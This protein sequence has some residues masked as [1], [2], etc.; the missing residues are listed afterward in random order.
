[1]SYLLG[2]DVGTSSLK[3]ALFDAECAQLVATAAEEYPVHQPV[4]NAAEQTP[5]TWW[6]AAL[7]AT[8]CVLQGVDRKRVRGIG[9]TGQM[10]GTVLLDAAAQPLRPAIIWADGRSSAQVE[11]LLTLFRES[12]W[13]D[14]AGTLPAT[15]FMAATL[16]WLAEHESETLERAKS[17][18]LPKDYIRLKLTGELGS[19]PSDAAS[20]AL[21]D[22][23]SANWSERLIEGLGLPRTLFPPIHGSAEVTGTLRAEVAE[24]LGLSAGLPVVAG[25][26]DQ[27]AQALANNVLARG[28]ASV[29]IGSG[30]QVFVPHMPNNHGELA[31]DQRVHV[32]NHAAPRHWY[33][34]GAILS[35]GLSLRWLRN[36][37]GWTND[38]EA[39]MR[40]SAAAESAPRGAGGLIF[41]PYLLGE[42]TPHRDPKARGVFIG[43]SYQHTA[44]HMARAVMEGVAFALRQALEVSFALAGKADQ[45]V[46]AG[47]GAQSAVWRQI[48][49]DIYGVALRQSLLREQTCVGAALLAGVGCGLYSSL[50]EACAVAAKLG[51]SIEPDRSACVYYEARYAQ[52]KALYAQL[53]QDMHLLADDA[54]ST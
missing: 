44:A 24:E 1:M 22:V 15:G 47:G 27:A 12:E 26:A 45:V 10:H 23:R 39:Y 43:L 7:K 54:S 36:L 6:S 13:L 53:R 34:L 33:V 19:E 37:L 28:T 49:A 18:L 17:V 4:P 25:C 48:Q 11:R 21:F 20:T 2:I 31:A 42:R 40:L 38:P 8:Q 5:E 51:D 46:L 32:F 50:L 41:L 52:F 16:L 29:T 9:L 35:A 14:I 30:G 3:A